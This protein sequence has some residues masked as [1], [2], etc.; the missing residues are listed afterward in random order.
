MRWNAVKK[1]EFSPRISYIFLRW[2]RCIAVNFLFTAWCG[3][4]FFF[5]ASS[6]EK[7]I[8]R[9]KRWKNNRRYQNALEKID[10]DSLHLPQKKCKRYA[11]KFFFT[12]LHRISNQKSPCLPSIHGWFCVIW[13]SA[14]ADF[15]LSNQTS[16]DSS[17]Q[18]IS[19]SN[20]FSLLSN[21]YSIFSIIQELQ[22]S[23][24]F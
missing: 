10:H 19:I 6:G 24:K 5:T 21:F 15:F 13:I 3:E 2:M 1:K 4:L 18:T 22:N 8:R 16:S 12:V 14:S 23:C 17:L 9:N 7:K 20:T 11:V